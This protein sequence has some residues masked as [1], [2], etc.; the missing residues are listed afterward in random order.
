MKLRTGQ[1]RKKR[2]LAKAT[3]TNTTI[4]EQTM[5]GKFNFK[6]FANYQQIINSVSNTSSSYKISTKKG[7]DKITLLAKVLFNKGTY[8]RTKHGKLN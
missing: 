4:K 7:K 5:K 3:L 8:I 2:K 6:P 1:Q